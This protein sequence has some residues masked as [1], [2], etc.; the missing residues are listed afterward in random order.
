MKSLNTSLLLLSFLLFFQKNLSAQNENAIKFSQ[1]ITAEDL[2]KHIFTLAADEFEGRETGKPGQKKAAAYLVKYFSE[3]G[4]KNISLQTDSAYL[5]KFFLQQRSWETLKFQSKKKSVNYPDD[6]LQSTPLPES[7]W[8]KPIEAVFAGY[9]IDNEAYNDY[10]KIDAAGK[11]LLILT[12]EPK[13][14]DGNPVIKAEKKDF[15]SN[16]AKIKKALE[17]GAKA[18]VIVYETDE[19]FG[20]VS[21]FYAGYMSNGKLTLPQNK[22]EEG[23]GVFYISPSGAARILNMKEKKFNEFVKNLKGAES[24][25][26]SLS[27]TTKFYCKAKGKDIPTENVL[28]FLEG[29]D[30]KDEVLA[31]TAHYDHIGITGGKINNGADDDA[32]GTSTVLEIAEAF[33]KAAEA[34]FRPRRSILFMTFTGEEKGLLGS[35]YYSE[36]PIIPHEKTIANLNID[37]IGR[38]D[39]KHEKD[40]NYVYVIGSDMLSTDLHQLSELTQKVYAPALKLDYR[41]NDINDPNQFYYRS[42]H[43]NFAKHNI[44]VIFYFTGVHEDYHRPTDDPEKIHYGKTADIARL[45]FFTAWELANGANRPR[46]NK[47]Q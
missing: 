35:E 37:M 32:S 38:L 2:K 45:V 8:E 27:A 43:Y 40:S 15:L 16:N 44:P 23:G 10:A 5:Q 31:I 12:G 14:K 33:S 30:L 18:A 19:L 9:G 25:A 41:Y 6:L 47:K 39:F 26:G 7:D 13:D 22:E 34:G 28:A 17:K 21:R 42:D 20:N 1:T 46:V 36:N 4:L 3:L 24:K 29:T 11:I